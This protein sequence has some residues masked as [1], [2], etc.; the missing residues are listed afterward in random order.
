MNQNKFLNDSTFLN[1]LD[2]L[3]VKEQYVKI[4][5]LSWHEE[6]IQEIQGRAISGQVSLA[7][8]STVRRTCN[9]TMFAEENENDLSNIDNLFSI[10]KKVK[11]EIGFKNTLTDYIDIYGDII[12][13]PLGIYVI[14]N[15]S[16]SHSLS[17]VTISL[18]L[19]DK[20]S[21]LNGDAGGVIPAS[22]TFHEREQEF[23][24][25]S[26]EI[27][28]PTIYQ[29]I[30]E[31]VNHFGNENLAKI[32]IS[33]IDSRIKQV[34]KYSGNTPLYV[35]KITDDTNVTY[36][37]YINESDVYDRTSN[38]PSNIY[39]I[40][41]YKYGE[42]IG[43]IYTDFTYPGELIGDAG[44]TVCDILDKIIG[45]L[46]NY[47][48]FYDVNGNFVFQEIKNYLNTTYTTSVLENMQNPEY[49]VDFSQGKSVYT[50]EGTNLVS[51]YS[52]AP[53][54]NNIKNDFMVWG[55]RETAA[56]TTVPIRYHLAIDDKPKIGNTYE[57]ALFT[58]NNDITKASL[59]TLYDTFEDFPAVGKQGKFY[60]SLDTK[61][62]YQWNGEE[63]VEY[64]ENMT[65]IT[66]KDWR[67]E[68]Y[69]QGVEAD[70]FGTDSNY[71]YTELKNE[72]PKLY[73]IKN[74][75]YKQE[76]LDNPSG[77]DFYLDII[78]T[79]S[80][81]SQ[82]SVQNIGRRSKV[83]SDN[84]VNCIF[85]PE[86]P[87]LVFININEDNAAEIR[88]ECERKSQDYV[89]L[90]DTIYS[91]FIPGGASNSAYGKVREL[92]YQYTTVNNTITISAIP[93]FYLEPNTRITVR[94]DASGIYGDYMISTISIPLDVAGLMS[95]S[96]YKALE[97]V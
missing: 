92:L 95:I 85:A 97:R 56:G 32:I 46:G 21:L 62:I 18:Q 74:G 55:I 9:L 94:D 30:Q 76:V 49:Q 58:D 68:L 20:M 59:P 89:Q 67:E 35:V 42:D 73:D 88:E 2:N 75:E 77:I 43:Y 71:Y 10:N 8:N 87:D 11:V 52:N 80:E 93:I 79:T 15:P 28:K 36:E 81:L 96:A 19:K 37:F 64:T 6:V 82:Y 3:R 22:V 61:L 31:L 17:G 24:D 69:F 57:V 7:G 63:Y 4:T 39:S 40:K 60:K 1:K 44:S 53:Q 26:I 65:Y 48:Y 91:L 34:M 84:D 14:F 86:I 90:E 41:E 12:W 50:F 25:G 78:D 5:A 16:L 38:L 66:T 13:F 27:T 23:E 51:A 83:L 29:I 47:E 45:V 54:F 33:D 70:P 72:W